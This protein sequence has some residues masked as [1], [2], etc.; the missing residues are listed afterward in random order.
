[1]KI[2]IL[3][4]DNREDVREYSKPE[5]WFG[6]APEALLQGF[7]NFPEHQIH[8]LSCLQ[9]PVKSPATIGPSISYHGL[10]VPKFGWLRTGYQGCVRA[11]RKQLRDIKPDIVHGQGT[12][13]DCAISTVFSGFPNVVTIHGNMAELARLFR[14]PVGSYGWLAAR[15]EDLTLKRTGGVFCN[16]EY[17]EN[18]VRPRQIRTWRVP[19]PLRRQFFVPPGPSLASGRCTVVNVGVISPRKRQLELLQH[20]AA[21]HTRGLDFEAQFIGRADENDPYCVAFLKA[22]QQATA[23]GYARYLGSKSTE[24]LIAIFDASHALI[25]FPS[26]EAFGLVVA[27]GLARGIKFFGSAVGG[28]KEIAAG[29]A[30]AEL[31]DVPDWAGLMA[32]FTRWLSGGHLRVPQART[33]MES[34]YHPRTIAGRHLEIYAEVLGL[35]QV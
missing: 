11:V 17:T 32:A 7:E 10:H 22:I 20:L 2:A 31:F 15:L 18:L 6:A 4:T 24:E 26:E 8:V 5:P 35:R 29:V 25:H 13:R 28:I 33:L 23:K 19:N 9:R 27:E 3:T 30:C 34:R 1:V 16:S 12:E 21:L 14:K